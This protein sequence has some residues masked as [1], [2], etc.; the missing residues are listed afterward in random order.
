M[1]S[2][3]PYIRETI[4]RHL[5]PKQAVMLTEF[6]K[7]KRD[8]QEHQNEIHSKLVAIMSDRLQVHARTFEVRLAFELE[9][10]SCTMLSL[11]L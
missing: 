5:S 1:I 8:Y 11:S 6:D 7:L 2:M 10:A 3:I 4:R 9:P